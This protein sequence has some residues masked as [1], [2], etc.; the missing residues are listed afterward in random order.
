MTG[1]FGGALTVNFLR[2]CEF[3]NVIVKGSTFSKNIA[4][5]AAGVGVFTREA[6]SSSSNGVNTNRGLIS[7]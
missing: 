6:Q 4:V 7:G 5:G 1:G 2:D 3:N